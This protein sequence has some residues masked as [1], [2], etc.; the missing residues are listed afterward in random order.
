MAP[1][2]DNNTRQEFD[3]RL[4]QPVPQRPKTLLQRISSG[5]SSMLPTITLRKGRTKTSLSRPTTAPV[6]GRRFGHTSLRNRF[7]L[8]GSRQFSVPQFDIPKLSEP[9]ECSYDA[10]TC[11]SFPSIEL[12]QCD[13]CCS[14]PHSQAISRSQASNLPCRLC[15][16]NSPFSHLTTGFRRPHDQTRSTSAIE[17][18][19]AQM[20]AD[21]S[22]TEEGPRLVPTDRA[23]GRYMNP[24]R[25]VTLPGNRVPLYNRLSL[26]LTQHESLTNSQ[27]QPDCSVSM[28]SGSSTSSNPRSRHA[29]DARPKSPRLHHLDIL[30]GAHDHPFVHR[31][32]VDAHM[33]A[34]RAGAPSPL[35]RSINETRNT[36]T[37]RGPYQDFSRTVFYGTT[38]TSA[39]A[40]R[41]SGTNDILQRV[42]TSGTLFIGEERSSVPRDLDRE[43]QSSR[44]YRRRLLR[45]DTQTPLPRHNTEPSFSTLTMQSPSTF[46]GTRLELKGGEEK[47][48]LRGGGRGLNWK[49][50]LL[51]CQA[52]YGKRCEYEE[53]SEDELLPA[54][55]PEPQRLERAT[56]RTKET[57]TVPHDV[58]QRCLIIHYGDGNSTAVEWSHLRS[59]LAS[60][61]P[62]SPINQPVPADFT[63]QPV[64][65]LRGGSGSQVR[66]PPTLYWLA[67]GKGKPGTISSWNKQKGKKRQGGLLGRM[68]YGTKSGMEYGNHEEESMVDESERSGRSSVRATVGSSNPSAR[69][70]HGGESVQSVPV[71]HEGAAP[72][73]VAEEAVPADVTLP[74]TSAD[75][76]HDAG[77]EQ[78][79]NAQGHGH[80]GSGQARS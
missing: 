14:K 28:A 54:R 23:A 3:S 38:T 48:R 44:V 4:A 70:M 65:T 18:S 22:S 29:S 59:R 73:V 19:I 77:V 72:V 36:A 42:E 12:T 64:P 32:E 55:A 47:M 7:S 33:A 30:P 66:L 50:W 13:C 16:A 52:P 37:P 27:R 56:Q 61:P 1:T 2:N 79:G 74:E 75:E 39:S 53:D 31:R 10:H 80:E 69:K 49:R 63:S 43:L 71:Q 60:T 24:P 67:G 45:N 40:R 57:A 78:G 62:D 25:I 6:H 11:Y 68:M 20:M 34:I 35:R 41:M 46:G 21:L 9:E 26:P 5:F 17:S 76:V 58:S 8:P 15:R 51:T